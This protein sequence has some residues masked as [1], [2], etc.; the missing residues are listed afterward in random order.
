[1]GLSCA[2]AMCLLSRID[3]AI[4]LAVNDL[5]N[6]IGGGRVISS[7]ATRFMRTALCRSEHKIEEIYRH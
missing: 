7:G 5:A 1:M 2:R 3:S 6:G 4:D